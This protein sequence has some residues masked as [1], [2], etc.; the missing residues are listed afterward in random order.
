MRFEASSARAEW[1]WWQLLYII[2]WREEK[3]GFAVMEALSWK[4]WISLMLFVPFV[5]DFQVRQR[6]QA[7]FK[8]NNNCYRHIL[9]AHINS[10]HHFAHKSAKEA[11][12]RSGPMNVLANW[13][14]E[15][16]WALY[17]SHSVIVLFLSLPELVRVIFSPR[18]VCILHVIKILSFEWI[19]IRK[20]MAMAL[21]SLVCASLQSSS[22]LLR[23]RFVICGALE[24][25]TAADASL[26]AEPDRWCIAV[27]QLRHSWHAWGRGS[28]SIAGGGQWRWRHQG[29][30][31]SA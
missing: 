18:S 2:K 20:N 21:P 24:V 10:M 25:F 6:K 30:S 3:A 14:N 11:D 26:L 7:H 5:H 29:I 31:A 19:W 23:W 1:K 8:H 27:G 13:M 15:D 9:D 4:W 16:L 17:I 12:D 28:R 22:L